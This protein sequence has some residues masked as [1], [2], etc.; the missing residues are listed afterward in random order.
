[1]R[2]DTKLRDIRQGTGPS[3]NP[4]IEVAHRL[5]KGVAAGAPYMRVMPSPGDW[6]AVYVCLNIVF[7]GKRPDTTRFTL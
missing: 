7:D 1:M 5:G 3:V 4:T 2:R 6:I